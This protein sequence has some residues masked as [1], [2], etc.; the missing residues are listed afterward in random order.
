MPKCCNAK[1]SKRSH[2]EQAAEAL[3]LAYAK[4]DEGSGSIDWADL[5]HAFETAKLA[6]PGR[7]EE[8][9]TQLTEAEHAQV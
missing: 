4:N 1:V 5:D 8:L 6:L 3:L 2:M 7:Y 9:V